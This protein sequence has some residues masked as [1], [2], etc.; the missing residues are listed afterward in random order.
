MKDND[1]G[2]FIEQTAL[3]TA[4]YGKP[5]EV[6]K[7]NLWWQLLA[8]LDI[9]D[10]K[11]AVNKHRTRVEVTLRLVIVTKAEINIRGTLF[12]LPV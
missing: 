1:W 3:I 12:N 6:A 9:N 7:Q 5:F 4:N 11:R 8:D 2:E 10:L